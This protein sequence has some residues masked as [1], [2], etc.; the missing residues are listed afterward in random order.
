MVDH[1][2][3]LGGLFGEVLALCARTGLVRAGAVAVAST[4]IAADASGQASRNY[5]L[6]VRCR[7]RGSEAARH[8]AAVTAPTAIDAPVIRMCERPQPILCEHGT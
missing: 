5:E 3:G 6:I 8:T 4:K 1:E 7:Q 2:A